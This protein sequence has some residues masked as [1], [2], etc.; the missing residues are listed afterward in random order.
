MMPQLNDKLHAIYQSVRTICSILTN[1][2]APP[3]CAGC[4]KY[5]HKEAV[6]CAD[7]ALQ[8]TP[9][10]SYQLP[11]TRHTSITVFAAS[12]YRGIV[13]DLIR[14]KQSKRIYATRSLA[15]LIWERTDIKNQQFDYIV[16]VPL[17]WSRYAARG[18]NQAAE[19]ARVLSKQSGKPVLNCLRRSRATRIQTGLSAEERKENVADL[20]YI[21]KRYAG[22]IRESKLLIVDDVLTTGATVEACV[23]ALRMERP[24][25]IIAVVAARVV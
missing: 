16:P 18:Y 22:R 6:L 4:K 5:L 10:A 12:A 15:I 19:I 20:F 3:L 8:I 14:A 11:I 13:Q 1:I 21:P 17:H 24:Q 23:R 9:I 2:I 25:S 7:C